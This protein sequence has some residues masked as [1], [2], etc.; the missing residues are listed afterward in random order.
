MK[1]PAPL[2]PIA[3]A[4]GAIILAPRVGAQAR[5]S[6]QEGP[7][8]IEQCQT[9]NNPGSYKLVKNLTATGDCLVIANPPVTIDLG[10]FS[11]TGNGTGTGIGGVSNLQT[12][13]RNGTISKFNT[14]VFVEGTI[15]GLQVA[16]CAEGLFVG[17]IV[18][19]NTVQFNTF[20]LDVFESSIVTGNLAFA[21][22]ETGIGVRG[23]S[24]IKGNNVSSNKIG[25]N[26]G[27]GST[28]IEN[29]ASNNS[30]IGLNVTCPSN[31]TNNTAVNNGANIMLNGNGCINT[32]NVMS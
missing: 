13:V 7:I 11:I 14:G 22:D 23:A 32:N 15:E 19:N 26:V 5:D 9:L 28:L 10:G 16:N 30:Q 6:R 27:V 29:I 8:E 24:L 17:G 2:F 25:I 12:V 3:L 31:V 1:R 21:N 4:I 20:G 18:K